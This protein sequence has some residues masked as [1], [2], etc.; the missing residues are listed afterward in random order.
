MT[1][2]HEATL[3]VLGAAVLELTGTGAKETERLKKRLDALDPQAGEIANQARQLT[4]YRK[5]DLERPGESVF[6]LIN[7]PPKPQPMFLAPQPLK[8]TPVYPGPES[9]S[10]VSQFR[11]DLLNDLEKLPPE[12]DALLFLLDKYAWAVPAGGPGLTFGDLA[13]LAAATAGILAGGDQNLRLVGAHIS[14][15]QEYI[16]SISSK[17]ALKSLR[18]RSFFLDLLAEDVA[19]RLLDRLGLTR[20]NLIFVAGSKVY[21]ITPGTESAL[22]A[23]N[24]VKDD[25]NKW[26]MKELD[27]AIYLAVGWSEPFDPAQLQPGVDGAPPRW[28]EVAE[29]IANDKA[30][31]FRSH[32][33]KPDFWATGPLK[34]ETCQV[35]HQETDDAGPLNPYQQEGEP[36]TRA[37][38]HCRQMF[39]LG[40]KLPEAYYLMTGRQGAPDIEIAGT[41]YFIRKQSD[42]TATL[43]DAELYAIPGAHPFWFSRHALQV[44][45]QMATFDHLAGMST[46]GRLLGV[47]RMDVDRLGQLFQS[48]LPEGCRDF[49]RT[50]ALSQALTRFFKLH[51]DS[52]CRRELGDGLSALDLAGK[53]GPRPVTV[54]YAG[55]DDLFIV[56][57]WDQALE[58]AFDIRQAFDRYTGG[59]LT[60]SGGM[61]AGDPG[62]P[63]HL[64]ADEAKAAE[65]AAKENG[66]NSIAPLYIGKDRYNNEK[67]RHKA[68]ALTWAEADRLIDR[69]LTPALGPLGYGAAAE[70]GLKRSFTYRLLALTDYW[71]EH[72]PLYL[73]KLAYLLARVDRRI[74]E[75]PAWPKFT[76]YLMQNRSEMRCLAPGIRWLDLLCR[77]GTSD[78]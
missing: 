9:A 3:A 33:Y 56:G 28:R 13:R 78:G 48:G 4:G 42:P 75:N 19:R 70:F 77:G 2:A 39:Q 7:R 53:T 51:L 55:G 18:A 66:R 76:E 27:G 6:S 32:W 45:D 36:Q 12:P 52:I 74:K 5:P 1:L 60:I 24:A 20:A 22:T 62:W 34:E 50:A 72:G 44:D 57:A 8:A 73:P 71:L 26:L 23:I 15:I 43:L 61:V 31:R 29:A 30:A 16:Y 67:T 11:Q 69:F 41:G 10:D 17:G 25:V 40:G 68:A 21:L 35:C 63:L 64:L 58:L 37:C 14:G 54:V 47:L 38:P 49:A 46:G 59:R 65:D